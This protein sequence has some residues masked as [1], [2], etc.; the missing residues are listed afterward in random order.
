MKRASFFQLKL[1]APAG[2]SPV[3]FAL[4][5]PGFPADSPLPMRSEL[6]VLLATFILAGCGP[7]AE[8]TSHAV[9]AAGLTRTF[10][11]HTPPGLIKHKPAPL[12]LVFHGSGDTGA[13]M[14]RF[15]KFS[16]FADREGF[17]VA[18]PDAIGANW[19]DGR[20]AATIFSHLHKVDDVAFTAALIADVS[21]KH[22]I[23][24]RRIFAAGFSNGGILA[25]LLGARLGDKLAAIAAVGGGI[26]EPLAPQFRPAAPLSVLIIHGTKDPMVPYDGGDVDYGGYGRIVSTAETVRLWTTAL[27]PGAKP[28]KGTLP[29]ISPGDGCRVSWTH[30]SVDPP[31]HQI[32]LFTVDG[33]GHAW[34]GGP[35]F[36]PVEVIGNVCRDF[37]ATEV[38]WDFFK[39]HPKP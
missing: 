29:D 22:N 9:E 7:A 19:N 36:L 30:W 33:G 15:S 17:I 24:P 6:I 3:H 31:K 12:I 2:A 32:A 28:E 38:I 8:T 5:V 16:Q 13:G 21:A 1:P 25:H 14:E 11:L 4:L 23:D 26:A 18:Y 20:E 10:H 27:A 35:Q 37:D 39:K 34:P